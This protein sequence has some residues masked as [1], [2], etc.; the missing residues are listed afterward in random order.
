MDIY[1]FNWT[2]PEDIKDPATKPILK[3]LGPYRFREYPDKHNITFHDNNNTVSYRKSSLFYFEEEASN[4][5]LNDI[6]SV[7]NL[8]A[9]GAASTAQYWG[10]F[11]QMSVSTSLSGFGQ[12][13]HVIKSVREILF[14]GYYDSMLTIGAMFESEASMFDTVGFLV[15][16]NASDLLTGKYNIH[17]G[18]GN[19]SKLGQIQRYKDLDEFSF[20]SGECRKLKGSPGEFHP[21]EHS[22]N[23]LVHLFTPEICRNLPYEYKEDVKIHSING[24][25]YYL[26]ERAIDNGTLYPENECFMSD[27]QLPSGVMNMSICNFGQPLFMSYPHF[28]KAD[29]SYVNAVEGLTPQQDLHESYMTLEPKSSITLETTARL[30]TNI[31]IRPFGSITL[32]KNVPRIMMPLFFIEQKFRMGEA[33]A[34]ELYFGLVMFS[35]M[36]YIGVILI[37][38]GLLFIIC[39]RYVSCSKTERVR[40]VEI[41]AK[42]M[43]SLVK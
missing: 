40:D 17:T 33:H 26:N 8:L 37:C 15:K 36:K 20:Y 42:E 19:M 11:K 6:V 12:K 16:K 7:V 13:I 30:Q 4:G 21:P 27:D 28:Y 35:I 5:T 3:Q 29:P 9:V 25:R 41:N 18:V 10:F 24:N 43:I 38:L 32:Y 22:K 14:E 34:S 31:L 2:N 1:L 23:D 39:R